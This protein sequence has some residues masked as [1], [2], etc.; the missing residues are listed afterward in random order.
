MKAIGFDR[1]NH[2]KRAIQRRTEESSLGDKQP[3]TVRRAQ[4]NF[5]SDGRTNERADKASY[6][7]NSLTS[8]LR[9]LRRN[10][11]EMAE[12]KR[13]PTNDRIYINKHTRNLKVLCERFGPS[14]IDDFLF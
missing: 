1:R 8:K 14:F 5:H 9:S 7:Q 12:H 13:S 6:R 10:E 11:T 3:K 4:N 2:G